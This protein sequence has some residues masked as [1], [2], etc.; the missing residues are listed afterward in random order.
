MPSLSEEPAA[1]LLARS[2]AARTMPQASRRNNERP[3]RASTQPAGGRPS[4]RQVAQRMTCEPGARRFAWVPSA[5][6]AEGKTVAEG[7]AALL[8][9]RTGHVIYP[10]GVIMLQTT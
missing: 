1:Q 7:C 8:A 2:G 6:A 9:T 10:K 5:T 4:V 3:L